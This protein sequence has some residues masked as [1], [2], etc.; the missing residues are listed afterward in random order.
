MGQKTIFKTKKLTT[1]VLNGLSLPQNKQYALN[2]SKMERG[3][4]YIAMVYL[5]NDET[6]A[7]RT[8]FVLMKP[9]QKMKKNKTN[10]R[11]EK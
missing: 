3:E 11:N 9:W 1:G 5:Y 2:T 10:M 8:L 4:F 6:R 7:H